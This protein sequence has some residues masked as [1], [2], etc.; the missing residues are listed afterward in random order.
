[1]IQTD[2]PTTDTTTQPACGL[3][4]ITFKSFI[5]AGGEIEILDPS[6]QAEES[7]ILPKDQGT[8][9]T[10]MEDTITHSVIMQSCCEHIEHPYPILEKND[11]DSVNSGASHPC[12]NDSATC[13]LDDEQSSRESAASQNDGTGVATVTW[14]T[15]LCDGGEV[16]ISDATRLQDETIPLLKVELGVPLEDST[17]NSTNCYDDVDQRCQEEHADHPYCS[18]D[19]DVPVINS[20]T[21]TR[22]SSEKSANGLTDVTFKLLDCTGGEI[23]EDANLEEEAVPLPANHTVTNHESHDFVID[24]SELAVDY[25]LQQDNHF[26]HPHCNV[27]THSSPPCGSLLTAQEAS[28]HNA[29]DVGVKQISLVVSDSHAESQEGVTVD[30]F[31]AAEDEKLNDAQMLKKTSLLPDNQDVICP[32]SENGVFT[33]IIHDHFHDDFEQTNSLLENDKTEADS[34]AAAVSRSSVANSSLKALGTENGNCKEM[35]K[36]TVNPEDRAFSLIVQNSQISECSQVAGLAERPSAV[37]IQQQVEHI[38]QLT[39]TRGLSESSEEQDSAIGS[40][41]NGPALC[42]SAEKSPAESLT[43]VLKA[44][45]ACPSVASALQLGMFSPVVGRASLSLLKAC[46][47]PARGKFA[48]DESALEVEKMLLAPLNIDSPGLWAEQLESPMPRPL[49][50]STT[51]RHKPRS[52]P[53]RDPVKDMG[54]KVCA[55]PQAEVEKPVLNFPLIPD[56]PLQQQLRQMAEFLLLASG[57]MGPSAVSSSAP[58][59]APSVRDTPVESHSVC[60]GS[61]PVKLVD[62]SLNTSGLFERKREFSVVDSC[63]VTDPLLWK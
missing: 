1:M 4:N 12:K 59:P 55:E 8:C 2:P 53:H 30:C 13:D 39:S 21:E 41:G 48:E 47:D 33:S 50:N 35:P 51:L 17:V 14:K 37:E 22:E 28:A 7:I 54:H 10:E 52:S 16:E 49:L 56:G 31:I 24:S 62:H 58:L 63:T 43:D 44:L 15:F 25:D 46:G 29:D 27:Q 5:C 18:N 42:N 20:F 19:S 9:N 40:S 45:S 36:C 61:S 57:K 3:S 34:D 26:D 32:L 38:S 23:S 6:L 60:V 11:P